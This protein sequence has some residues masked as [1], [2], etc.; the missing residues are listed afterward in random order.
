M[1]SL[2][3]RVISWIV[4]AVF[5]VHAVLLCFRCQILT[6]DEGMFVSSDAL[7]IRS[8]GDCLEESLTSVYLK[9]NQGK[10][11]EPDEVFVLNL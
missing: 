11:L 2:I 10:S 8:V 3:K 1:E 9:A 6:C 4:E 5:V 7:D